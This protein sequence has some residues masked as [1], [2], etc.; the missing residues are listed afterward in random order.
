[1]RRLP[2]FAEGPSGWPRHDVVTIALGQP[3][4]VRPWVEHDCRRVSLGPTYAMTDP[5]PTN[6]CRQSARQAHQ[7]ACG[8]H[9]QVPS[10]E[11]YH[12]I[13]HLKVCRASKN[14]HKQ[15]LSVGQCC[16]PG[17]AANRSGRPVQGI[18]ASALSVFRVRFAP[19]LVAF[20]KDLR[21]RPNVM[22]R[23]RR[24]SE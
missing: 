12:S 2:P 24:F 13:T 3:D 18:Q 17:A 21:P 20:A 16:L 1:M 11:P 6:T 14:P 19:G 8:Y 4:P 23:S 5:C 15:P 9:R 10:H 22:A 7:V